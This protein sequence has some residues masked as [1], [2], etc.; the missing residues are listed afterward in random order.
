MVCVVIPIKCVVVITML[1][2]LFVRNKENINAYLILSYIVH[3][4]IM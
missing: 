4:N 1:V 2:L 3:N